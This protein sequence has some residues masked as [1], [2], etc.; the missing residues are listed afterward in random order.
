MFVATL[1]SEA[2]HSSDVGMQRAR[3]AA[4]VGLRAGGGRVN[5]TELYQKSP[6]RVLMPRVDGR[7]RAEIVFINSSGGITGGDEL[8]YAVRADG[9]AT[10]M[11]TTQASEK[12]YSAIDRDARLRMALSAGDGATLE[13]LPQQTIAFDGARLRRQTSIDI[14]GNARLLALDWLVMGRQARGETMN[15]GALRDEWRVRRDGRLVWADAL[16]LTGDLAGLRGSRASLGG[17]RAFAT[18]V[19]AGPDA[20]DRLDLARGLIADCGEAGVTVVGGVLVGRFLAP[21]G[22]ALHKSVS[23]FLEAFRTG[24]TGFAPWPPRLWTC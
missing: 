6:C 1:P 7:D 9:A 8:D 24:L 10:T 17:N 22:L 21:D 3:G 2:A 19:Y 4:R 15:R 18:L 16:R 13:W 14:T 5:I 11:A 12:I 20:A 23:F